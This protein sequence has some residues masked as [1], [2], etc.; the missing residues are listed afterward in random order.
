VQTFKDRVGGEHRVE[1]YEV[2]QIDPVDGKVARVTRKMIYHRFD[3]YRWG[4]DSLDRFP[5]YVFVDMNLAMRANDEGVIRVPVNYPIAFSCSIQC[6]DGLH[7]GAF[8]TL[9]DIGRPLVFNNTCSSSHE[10]APIFVD[11][12]ARAYIGTLW[13]VGN[14]TATQA[15][16]AFYSKALQD[17]NILSAFYEMVKQPT[18]KKD[19]NVYIYWGLHF[20]TLRRPEQ[21][22]DE[23][24]FGALMHSFLMW[25]TKVSGSVDP[26]VKSHGMPILAF[27]YHQLLLNFTQERLDKIRDFDAEKAAQV[28]G[29]L[30]AEDEGAQTRGYDEMIVESPL[31]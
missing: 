29:N 17:G 21:R 18:R 14:A 19:I 31:S 5:Q 13:E 3:G 16:K 12:G 2:L 7:Q 26:V 8:Q 30:P 27:L 9:S 28:I 11:A 22:S 4:S 20:S 23:G 10:L 25:M 15:A 1:Y 24:I 6:R